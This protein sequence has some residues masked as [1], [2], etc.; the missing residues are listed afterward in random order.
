ML[1][2][3]LVKNG[4]MSVL[5]IWDFY[6]V[7]DKSFQHD[8]NLDKSLEVVTLIF[9]DKNRQVYSFYKH[10]KEVEFSMNIFRKCGIVFLSNSLPF[11]LHIESDEFSQ[12]YVYI[13]ESIT[14]TINT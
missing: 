7:V 6:L 9:S 11:Y 5:C 3:Y 13:P 8:V 12:S 4:I 10:D 2:L 1:S 14:S